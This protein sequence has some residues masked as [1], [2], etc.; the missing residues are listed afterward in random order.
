MLPDIY[1]ESEIYM[2]WKQRSSE[3]DDEQKTTLDK[4]SKGTI[5]GK[6]CTFCLST[7]PNIARGLTDATCY[8]ISYILREGAREVKDRERP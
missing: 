5:Y 2:K 1:S 8:A 3:T 4:E 7:R 6:Y